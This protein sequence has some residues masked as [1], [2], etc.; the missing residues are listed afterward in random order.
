MNQRV[1]KKLRRMINDKYGTLYGIEAR[2]A[3]QALKKAYKENPEIH[4]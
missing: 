1:A 2:R 4:L 3:Y